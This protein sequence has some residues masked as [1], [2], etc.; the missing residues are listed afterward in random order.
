MV[1]ESRKNKA[2]LDE[3]LQTLEAFLAQRMQED[4]A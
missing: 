1:W 4:Y 3:V 2:T